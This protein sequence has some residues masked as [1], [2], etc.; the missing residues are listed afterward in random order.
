M[1]ANTTAS[2]FQRLEFLKQCS[3]TEAIGQAESLAIPD[4]AAAAAIYRDWIAYHPADPLLHAAYFNYGVALSRAGDPS[5]AI[6]A[7]RENLRVKPD[8]YAA[9]INLGR[10]L[11]DTGQK[12]EAVSEW[13][14]LVK[15]LAEINGDSVKNKLSALQQIGRVLE[16]LN[17]DTAAEDALKQALDI[18]VA[19]PE[20][21]QHW[22][23][24]RQRQCKWPV[25]S[26]WEYVRAPQL[27]AEIS[28][29]SLCNLTDDPVFQLARA[30]RYNKQSLKLDSARQAPESWSPPG[31]RA[32]GK[33]R[34][35]YVSSDLREHAVGFAMTDVIEEH[36][37]GR[38]DIYAYYCGINRVDPTQER[39]KRGVDRW[40][41]INGMSDEEAAAKIRKDKIDIIVDLNGYTKDARTRVFALR[42]APIAVN[43]FG[44]PGTMASPYHHYIIADDAIIPPS[45]EI[46]YSEKVLRLACYQPND[47]KR[48]IA[49]NPPSRR[50]EGLPEGALVYCSLNGPQKFTP[51]VF[52]AW[53]AILTRTPGSV[54]W[55]LGAG[56]DAN[57][58]LRERATQQ[59]LAPERLIF[60]QKKPNPEH[61]ARYAL[62]DL[63]LD[64]F[65]YGAHTTASDAM[66]MGVPILTMPGKG[67]ASRVCASLLKAAGIGELIC[68]T[69]QEYIDRAV[70]LGQSPGELKALRQ[71]LLAGRSASLLFDTPRLVR[72][73]ETLYQSMW[74]D[75]QSGALPQPDLANLDIYE[76]VGIDL[77]LED[78][79][80]L[81]EDAYRTT[82]IRKLK[83]RHAV[84]PIRTDDR[85]WRGGA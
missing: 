19:Q 82:Y 66:W 20:V 43:W 75:F 15:R 39:I 81:S 51:E 10:L 62:A 42:P 18:S 68:V 30:W 25:I 31:S 11:E 58:R 13:L 34:I 85:L 23:S 9:Y 17:V 53:M 5:G 63:F 76:E 52:L 55:L 22:I 41:D 40:T 65:P 3:L 61:L 38:F 33:L 78:V 21:I 46:Y 59:G 70:A 84:R 1:T 24:L 35:G 28:P 14:G 54:L 72:D 37:R 69:L 2:A 4:A 16:G 26:A 79:S 48:T 83:E 27:I 67:F 49:A 45:Q 74:A 29:L 44:F 71:R 7:T 56:D 80:Y 6:N 77:G 36:D 60:A 57:N 47:R 32:S 8:F 64:T 73:L 50:D 12:G